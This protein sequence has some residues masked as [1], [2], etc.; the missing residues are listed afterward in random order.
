[1]GLYDINDKAQTK[2]SYC[3]I[4]QIGTRSPHPCNKTSQSPLLQ[5]LLNNQHP[6]GT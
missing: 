1:M 2:R 6:H 5:C 4:K 3:S